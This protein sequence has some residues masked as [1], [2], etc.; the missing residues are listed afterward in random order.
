MSLR[1]RLASRWGR[2][3]ALLGALERVETLTIGALDALLENR[4]PAALA[5]LRGA[6]GTPAGTLEER[7]A[8]MAAAQN[9]RVKAL[10]E[11]LGREEAV[12]IGR[13]ALFPV[14]VTLGREARKRL[15]VGDGAEE[16]GRAA[17][18][19]YRTLGIDFTLE[20]QEGGGMMMRVH[21]CA[22]ADRYSEEACEILSAADEG[23]VAGLSPKFRMRFE[24]RMT[25]GRSCCLARI[26]E[27]RE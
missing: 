9:A 15:D 26:W 11:E 22:L 1:L 2:G 5:G 13:E 12:R 27:A 25:G 17:A 21:R 4:A 14:G 10:V 24:Q 7:R 20:A 6:P 19:L 18:I 23:V 3:N 16:L 8:A